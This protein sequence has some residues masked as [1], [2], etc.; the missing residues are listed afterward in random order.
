MVFLQEMWSKKQF[1][2]ELG[3]RDFKSSYFGSVFG[4][5]WAIIEPLSY[6]CLLYFFIGRV[7]KYQPSVSSNYLQWL[8]LGMMVWSFFS[9]S[10]LSGVGVYKKYSFLLRRQGF[11]LSVLPLVTLVSTSCVHFIFFSLT[12]VVL[13]LGDMSPSWIWLQAIY[14][15]LCAW[16]L[17]VGLIWLT[18][19]LS[20]FA[21]DVEHLV[22]LL[23]QFGFWASPIFWSLDSFPEKFHPFL[24]LN[25]VY[26]LITGY[27]D[28]F[29]HQIPFW[30]RPTDLVLYWSIT[31]FV[32]IIGGYIYSRLRPHF[33]DVLNG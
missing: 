31:I 25:P 19:S 17:L 26:Y 7:A 27:R 4:L 12:L 10:L 16:V 22:S 2:L 11:S 18:A 6:V 21:K 28:T 14:Y 23:V 29:I 20:V 8:M 1:I 5:L 3:F 13:L 30:E 33:G 32:L 9:G 15:L 24:K